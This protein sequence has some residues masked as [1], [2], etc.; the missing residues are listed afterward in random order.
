MSHKVAKSSQMRR[1]AATSILL[2][3]LLA[4]ADDSPLHDVAF[5]ECMRKQGKPDD[6]KYFAVFRGA[7]R[8]VR[9]ELR[10]R[11]TNTSRSQPVKVTGALSN[12][13]VAA[14]LQTVIGADT[15]YWSLNATLLF[16]KV[17]IDGDERRALIS[18]SYKCPVCGN[19]RSYVYTYEQGKWRDL[20]RLCDW[21]S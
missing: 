4:A 10:Q 18:L 5:E 16:Y 17:Y 7:T 15:F 12:V 20:Y 1:L 13:Q 8:D 11:G 21:D 3:P 14:L 2:F 9:V 19:G 6:L